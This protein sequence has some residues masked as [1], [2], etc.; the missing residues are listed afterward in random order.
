[1]ADEWVQAKNLVRQQVEIMVNEL[2][3]QARRIDNQRASIDVLQKERDNAVARMND[4][5]T[6]RMQFDNAE[7]KRQVRELTEKND[8]YREYMRLKDNAK[9][10][11]EGQRDF[12]KDQAQE[13]KRI[14]RVHADRERFHLS[15]IAELEA[16]NAKQA[17]AFAELEKRSAKKDEM[18]R[19]QS[20]ENGR[21]LEV[22]RL[23]R[24]GIESETW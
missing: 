19:Q 4:L 22:I 24:K 21:L 10:K 15:R 17:E 11:V 23:G 5:P 8:Q 20:A 6:M 3:S 16:L 13:A 18:I 14:S 7:L 9:I 2:E 1:M 12:A